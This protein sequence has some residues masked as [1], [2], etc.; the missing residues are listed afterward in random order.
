MAT[1]KHEEVC[2]TDAATADLIS[3]LFLKVKTIT[4]VCNSA[5]FD[6]PYVYVTT[7]YNTDLKQFTSQN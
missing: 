6:N 1:V 5:R 4:G 2:A 7:S 3:A